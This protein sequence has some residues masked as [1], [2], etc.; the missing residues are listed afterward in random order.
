MSTHAED[1]GFA[2][3]YLAL[4]PGTPV[5]SADGQHLG[6]VERV[7]DN[8][9]EHI[10]DGIVL[11]APGGLLWVDA[12]EVGR[13]AERRVTLTLTAEEAEAQLG[14]Y[15]AGAPEFRADARAGRLSRFFGGGGWRRS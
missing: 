6:T 3:S 5:V 12:P 9:K 7:I 13:I 8:A 14:P 2:I 4:A 15:E 10:F 11:E 1:E